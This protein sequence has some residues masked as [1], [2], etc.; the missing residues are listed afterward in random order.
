M[1]GLLPSI[2][3]VVLSVKC[4]SAQLVAR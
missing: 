3:F 4:D 2:S 1:Y